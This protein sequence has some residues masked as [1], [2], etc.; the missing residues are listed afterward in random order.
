MTQSQSV[1]AG[2]YQDPESPPGVVRYWDGL[3][4]APYIRGAA[5]TPAP[6]KDTGALIGFGLFAL[7]AIGAGIAMFTS[8]SL[9]TGT[10][11]VW[12]GA[13]MACVAAVGAVIFHRMRSN[14]WL[15]WIVTESAGG[16]T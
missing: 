5:A 3:Q 7:A 14:A 13:V 2:W 6:A 8:V 11:T 15:A 1:A 10:G 9:L 4:W 16:N 12:M